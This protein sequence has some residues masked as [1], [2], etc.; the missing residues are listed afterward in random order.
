MAAK[1]LPPQTSRSKGKKHDPAPGQPCCHSPLM[2]GVPPRLSRAVRRT[3]Q[4]NSIPRL[5]RLP[6]PF[7]EQWVPATSI[8]RCLSLCTYDHA[9]TRHAANTV[10]SAGACLSVCGAFA[11]RSHAAPPRAA[12]PPE[13][14]QTSDALLDEILEDLGPGSRCG[15]QTDRHTARRKD[16]RIHNW[17]SQRSRRRRWAHGGMCG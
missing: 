8:R 4:S 9:P 13:A 11:A 7:V 3:Q 17:D 14:A 12:A 16:A 10:I 2:L 6:R 5:R 15:R 1:G